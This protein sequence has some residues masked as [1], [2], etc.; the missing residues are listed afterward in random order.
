MEALADGPA[1]VDVSAIETVEI[2]YVN[3]AGS[4]I[5]DTVPAGNSRAR[6]AEAAIVGPANKGRS[7]IEQVITGQGR[8]AVME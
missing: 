2:G 3:G 4:D 8:L 1:V 7:G 5:N 6:E